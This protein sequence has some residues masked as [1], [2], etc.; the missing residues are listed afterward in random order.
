[1]LTVLSFRKISTTLS[2]HIVQPNFSDTN[3]IRLHQI[4][5]QTEK[6]DILLSIVVLQSMLG[7]DAKR[8]ID[9]SLLHEMKRSIP[10][11]NEIA[12]YR[13]FNQDMSKIWSNVGLGGN[14]G[15]SWWLLQMSLLHNHAWM[16]VGIS[17][18]IL[19][20]ARKI[21]HARTI[22]PQSV[23]GLHQFHRTLCRQSPLITWTA[24]RTRS[25]RSRRD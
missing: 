10:V 3:N 11:F 13:R 19:G 22:W 4:G 20:R 8:R 21:I 16:K 2:V 12:S 25:R 6:R 15:P 1:M 5:S 24:G 17:D 7:M 9:R 14:A 18:I 23:I